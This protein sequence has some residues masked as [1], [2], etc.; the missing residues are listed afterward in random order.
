MKTHKA[1]S[2]W[3]FDSVISYFKGNYPDEVKTYIAGNYTSYEKDDLT[4]VESCIEEQEQH[5]NS[6]LNEYNRLKH[7]TDC[8]AFFNELANDMLEIRQES[9]EKHFNKGV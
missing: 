3:G 4:V 6:L 5:L 9:K 1:F 2:V 7:I 8:S